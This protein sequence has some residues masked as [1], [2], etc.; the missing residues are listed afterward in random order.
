MDDYLYRPVWHQLAD[1]IAIV[2][3]VFMIRVLF[4]RLSA[5]FLVMA[6]II[7]L[8][9]TSFVY[10][11]ILFEY[12]IILNLFFPLLTIITT[13]FALFFVNY[14]YVDKQRRFIRNKFANKVS[15]A[16]VND[17]LKHQDKSLLEGVERD[18]SVFFS[19]VRGFTTISEK[20]T[21]KEVIDLLN[22]YMTPMS[23]IIMARNGTIDKFIGDAIM[24]YWNAPSDVEYHAEQAVITALEQLE[25][26]DAVN[27]KLLKKY[28]ISID[29]GIGIHSGMAVVG[30]MGSAGRSDYTVIGDTVN[31]AA[32]IETS[33]KKYGARLIISENTFSALQETY[34]VRELDFIVVKGKAEP[35]TIFEVLGK[36]EPDEEMAQIL[37]EHHSALQLYRQANFEKARTNFEKLLN[38]GENKVLYT[39]YINRCNNYI[40]EPPPMPF[41]GIYIS[42]SK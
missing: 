15:M 38:K 30:E 26:L 40:K 6:L 5:S 33:C 13:F 10:Y 37:K 3:L 32:R 19:D 9:F 34:I 16:V 28:D 20:L 42:T 22:I 23:E 4:G 11:W 31:L 41:D 8:V 36:G 12:H 39:K 14:I 27:K 7:T 24:A 25:G 35:V 17:I 1:I 29:I 18:I 21:A 2:L